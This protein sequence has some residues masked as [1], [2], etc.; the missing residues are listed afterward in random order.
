MKLLKIHNKHV[1]N[2]ALLRFERKV[3][4]I[5]FNFSIVS[6]NRLLFSHFSISLSFNSVL[7]TTAFQELPVKTITVSSACE[8][9]FLVE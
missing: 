6:E 7:F 5:N 4:V 1:S 3:K 2:K 9:G 8:V